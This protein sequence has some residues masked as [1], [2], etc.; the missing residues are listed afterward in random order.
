M[1]VLKFKIKGKRSVIS[2]SKIKKIIAIRKKWGLKGRRGE[3]FGS[4]PHSKGDNFSRSRKVFFEKRLAI[5]I[6][7]EDRMNKMDTLKIIINSIHTNFD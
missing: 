6:I 2:T 4:N 7:R 5:N 1:E 3:S